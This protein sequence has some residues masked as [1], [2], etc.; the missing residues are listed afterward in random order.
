MSTGEMN[1]CCI[2]NHGQVESD[3]T[4]R[5]IHINVGQQ[6]KACLMVITFFIIIEVQYAP[7]QLVGAIY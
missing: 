7:H 2:V 1:C 3:R 4:L 6:R 5:K